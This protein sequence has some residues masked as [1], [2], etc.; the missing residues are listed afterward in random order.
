MCLTLGDQIPPQYLAW[1]SVASWQTAG[2][3][4]HLSSLDP[5]EESLGF[6]FKFSLLSFTTLFHFRRTFLQLLGYKVSSTGLEQFECME[7]RFCH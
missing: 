3:S 4:W 7:A 1:L 2:G 6:I 5:L